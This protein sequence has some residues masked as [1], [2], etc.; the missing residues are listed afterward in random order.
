MINKDMPI[1]V[2]KNTIDSYNGI[3]SD[4]FMSNSKLARPKSLMYNNGMFDMTNPNIYKALVP[5]A[6]LPV[7]DVLLYK[8]KAPNALF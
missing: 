2:S 1:G 6:T 7:P 4:V 3:P 8:A 5:I